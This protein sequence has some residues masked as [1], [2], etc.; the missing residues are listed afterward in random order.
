M[1]YREL[2]SERARENNDFNRFVI[3]PTAK[4]FESIKPF[5]DRFPYLM[6]VDYVDENFLSLM[7]DLLGYNYLPNEDAQVQREIIKR[8]VNEYHKK[9]SL[10]HIRA[11]ATRGHS[12]NFLIGDLTYYKG[13]IDE[14]YCNIE[15][16]RDYMFRYDV[17]R[18]DSNDRWQD[19]KTVGLGIMNIQVSNYSEKTLECLDKVVPGGIKFNVE[20]LSDIGRGDIESSVR[21]PFEVGTADQIIYQDFTF[22]RLH[23]LTNVFRPDYDKWNEKRYEGTN[24]EMFSQEIYLTVTKP[25]FSA[26]MINDRGYTLDTVKLKTLKEEFQRCEG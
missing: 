23:D 16:L 1:D 17:S 20:Q 5:V 6:D 8:L 15:Y 11:A 14:G 13:L 3:E 2:F 10:D 19:G 9:G 12:D 18:W 22:M 25:S 7:S 21:F 24:T 4:M 26:I